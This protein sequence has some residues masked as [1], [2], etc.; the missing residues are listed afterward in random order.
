MENVAPISLSII[1]CDRV[2]FD[3]I[4]GMPSVINIVQNI[5]APQY[6][7]RH[8]QIMFF[9]ELINGH[10]STRLKVR[11]VDVEN[12]DKAIFEQ[13]Q[14]VDFKDV[15]QVVTLAVNMLGIVFQHP[16][17]YRFQL[18]ANE[19]PLGERSVICRQVSL[20]PSGPASFTTP[21]AQ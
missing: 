2:I 1:I 12:Q 14:T 6:P 13:G 4:T 3:R 17:E 7:V 21:E 15:K 9:C 10:G 8:N 16:G 11:L 19:T 18:F 5:N 20:P